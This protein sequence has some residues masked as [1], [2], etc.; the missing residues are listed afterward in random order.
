M[1]VAIRAAAVASLIL[2]AL[3]ASAQDVPVEAFATSNKVSSPRLSTDG[4]HIAVSVDLGE[5]NHGLAV[6]RTEDMKQTTLLRLPRYEMAAQAQWVSPTRL[7]IAKG[8]LL[9]S[10][11]QP[12]SMGEIVATDFD[13]RNQ[14]YIFGYQQSTRSGNIEPGF[15]HIA[16]VPEKPNGHFYLRR[17]SRDSNRSQLYDVDADT[18]VARLVAD[19]GVR[20]LNFVLDRQG[21]P[22]Y[23]YGTDD[24]NRYLL[25]TAGNQAGG[26]EWMPM[27]PPQ[28]GA[29]WTP[30]GFSADGSQVFASYSVAG[31]PV[32]FVRSRPDASDRQVL[33]SDPL[34]SFGTIEWSSGPSLPF[35]ATLGDGRPRVVYFDP[36]SPDAKLHD[37]L[38]L[39]FPDHYIQYVDHS[40][41]G[42]VTLLYAYSDRDPGSWYLFDRVKRKASILLSSIQGLDASR[43]G[44]RRPFRFKAS[45]GMELEGIL[46]LPHDIATPEKLPVV[47]LPHGGPH[48]IRDGWAFD[49]DAQ[50]LASRGYL[51]LQVNFRG[52]G[53]RGR[54]FQEAGYLKWGTRMQDDVLDGLRWAIAQGYADADRVC[55]FGISF[56][57]YSAMMLAAKE[58]G[59]IKC[60]AGMSG[61]YDLK[62][63]YAKG[64]IHATR[65]GNN[66]LGRAIGRSEGELAANSPTSLAA[67]I[68]VPV[69]LAHGELDERTPIAQAQAMKTALERAGNVPEWMQVRGEGH[70]FHADS[71]NIA[72][73]RRLEAFLTRNIGPRPQ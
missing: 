1:H 34:G 7:V 58:P 38:N 29:Q 39:S 4:R 22:R 35:A 3:H 73:Y 49:L 68:R 69:F 30:Y 50:F 57:A 53:G 48:G 2:S 63:M 25:Y 15:G 40:S 27:P 33:A 32:M 9:G 42:N 56:G 44:E 20:D 11:E 5:G 60:A 28:Q 66:Y 24:E 23:A 21:I 31:G 51:V 26:K 13:G 10:R 12:T 55:T 72:F 36:E 70:G 18:A 43:M 19:I 16:G 37:A 65:W 52:S 71:N 45:D 62:M 61:V 17:L 54:A 64:D 6:Y 14:K 8:R 47:V 46:T 41:D 67:R 59:L